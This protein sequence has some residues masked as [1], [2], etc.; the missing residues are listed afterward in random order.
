MEKIRKS[1]LK[2][3]ITVVSESVEG[4]CSI[5]LGFWIVVGS[6]NEEKDERGISHFIEHTLFKGTKRRSPKEI[7][8]ALESK[9]ATLDAFTSKEV[10]C[11]YSR[12]LNTHLKLATDV[13]SD[14]IINPIFPKKEIEKEIS[15]VTEEIKDRQDSPDRHI[16]D[17][18][19]K[20]TFFGHPL[21]NSVLGKKEDIERL[22]RGKVSEYFKKWY[23]PER[24]VVTA[25][26]Y[27]QH[28]E[29]IRYLKPCSN[30]KR[31]ANNLFFTPV[32]NHYK[33]FSFKF[34]KKGFFQTHFVLATPTF[35][36][37]DARRYPLLILDTVL[38][39]GM[40][41]ILFQ[42]IRE[43][44]ALVYQVF[45]FVDFFSD[46]G[47]FGVY[48]ACAPE[49]IEKAKMAV[50]KEFK[51]LLK[52]GLTKNMVSE[53]KVRL[54]AKLLI[55]QENI[56]NRMLRLGR[57]E[58]YRRRS[59]TIDEIISSINKVKTKQVNDVIKD[60]LVEDKLSFVYIGDY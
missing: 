33:P 3:G 54:K 46:A 47:I 11:F 49:K 53:T 24:I 59:I 55:G 26:G 37:N 45:S 44:K 40:S 25:S 1:Q 10:T 52:R 57:S 21:A 41:S 30:P 42:K 12:G 22:T 17:L 60:V 23:T 43:E 20:K 35:S 6:R 56:S 36:Y 29:L 18:L 14:L 8:S 16:F 58:I 19:F 48:L 31:A 34:K 9:G 51:K 50:I 15:V 32:K 27:L 4:V 7:A 38:G 5:S 2:N 28:D 13:I 39:D